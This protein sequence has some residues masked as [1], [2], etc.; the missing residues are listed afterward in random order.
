MTT[1][2]CFDEL[3]SLKDKAKNN[4]VKIDDYLSVIERANQLTEKC[5]KYFE[6]VESELK[7]YERE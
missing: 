2:E 7:Q 6:E 3:K 1:Q 4:E 5:R